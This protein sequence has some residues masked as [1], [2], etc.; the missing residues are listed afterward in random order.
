[1][2]N[3]EPLTAANRNCPSLVFVERSRFLITFV[4]RR[5]LGSITLGTAIEPRNVIGYFKTTDNNRKKCH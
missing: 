1:M 2:K 4:Q 3:N 5:K